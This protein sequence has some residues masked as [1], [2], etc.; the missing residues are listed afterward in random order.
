M[1]GGGAGTLGLLVA[2]HRNPILIHVC[3][4]FLT[5]DPDEEGR[6]CVHDAFTL[7]RVA[8]RQSPDGQYVSH[9]IETD[10]VS[11]RLQVG[12]CWLCLYCLACAHP[13]TA[14]PSPCACDHVIIA[15]CDCRTIQIYARVAVTPS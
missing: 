3:E 7:A 8:P 10:R 14:N 5:V 15:W 2:S 6:V 11:V 1:S 4:S 13:S 12:P 9:I